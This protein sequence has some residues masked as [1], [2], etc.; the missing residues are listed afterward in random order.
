M[1]SVENR[2]SWERRSCVQVLA[3]TL[4]GSVNSGKLLSYL[5]SLTLIVFSTNEK[6]T[7]I[8]YPLESRYL[9]CDHQ[10]ELPVYPKDQVIV[11]ISKN[12]GCKS[13][14]QT[15]KLCENVRHYI[16]SP[17]LCTQ[18]PSLSFYPTCI[19][20]SRLSQQIKNSPCSEQT[21]LIPVF[22]SLSALTIFF[23][24]ILHYFSIRQTF[25]GGESGLLLAKKLLCPLPPK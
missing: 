14:G 12:L 10:W 16:F 11:S 17:P 20:S 19:S 21:F 24:L 9:T 1:Y 18:I 13:S 5:T 7:L 15:Q 3:P 22:S 2:I 6:V 25:C 4:T 8:K 23:G